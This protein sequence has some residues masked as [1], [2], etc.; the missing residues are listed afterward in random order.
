MILGFEALD[1]DGF[2]DGAESP[3]HLLRCHP[4]W[5][6]GP[7]GM[8]LARIHALEPSGLQGG[9]HPPGVSRAQ[10]PWSVVILKGL[11]LRARG[12][13]DVHQLDLRA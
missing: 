2:L 1:D 5:F 12:N 8:V 6:V 13:P 9:A 11:E 10:R 7:R 4:R 3:A